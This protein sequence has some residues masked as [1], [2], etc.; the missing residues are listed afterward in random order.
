MVPAFR[1]WTSSKFHEY[2]RRAHS[3]KPGRKSRKQGRQRENAENDSTV[4]LA[5]RRGPHLA[6]PTAPPSSALDGSLAARIPL[7]S[8]LGCCRVGHSLAAEVY[9]G[10]APPAAGQEASSSPQCLHKESSAAA[11]K[12][13]WYYCITGKCMEISTQVSCVILTDTY[14]LRQL[15]LTGR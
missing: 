15:P 2:G 7:K 14:F 13:T 10:Q 12:D 3:R 4:C 6:V 11:Y 5:H 9:R 1:V 8:T